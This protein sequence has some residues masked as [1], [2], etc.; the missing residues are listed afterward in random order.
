MNVLGLVSHVKGK[1]NIL[2]FKLK[3][4]N[5]IS[6]IQQNTVQ[7]TVPQHLLKIQI[8]IDCVVVQMG[9]H[10]DVAEETIILHHHLTLI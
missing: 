4:K 10:V 6:L 3:G 1:L 8:Q 7:S 5:V 9:K 2:K